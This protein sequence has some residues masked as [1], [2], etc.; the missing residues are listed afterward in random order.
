[1][2]NLRT[3]LK[4]ITIYS[5]LALLGFLLA[6]GGSLAFQ[7]TQAFQRNHT[8]S[9]DTAPSANTA[10]MQPE[11][12]PFREGVNKA[13]EAAKQTQTAKT[14]AEWATVAELW[15]GAIAAMRS[16][17]QEHEKYATAQQKATEYE[18]NLEYAQRNNVTFIAQSPQPSPGQAS[19]TSQKAAQLQI[20]MPYEKVV[21]IMGRKPDTFYD[22]QIRQELGRAVS[23]V[24]TIA[25]D[26]KNDDTDCYPISVEFDPETMT[27]TSWDEGKACFGPSPDNAPFGKPCSGSLMCEIR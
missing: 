7:R 15:E 12:D 8:P 25:F 13:M 6:V 9:T 21:E 3:V 22:D 24:S 2:A 27:V 20:G 16:V 23:G 5:G 4:A 19:T 18:K 11:I 17:P 14:E 10:V 1:M 26:W